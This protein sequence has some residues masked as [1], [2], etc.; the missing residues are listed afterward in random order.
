MWLEHIG[1]HVVMS[2]EDWHEDE[3]ALCD[4][5]ETEGELLGCMIEDCKKNV[6]WQCAEHEEK[7]AICKDCYSEGKR[8]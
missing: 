2:R 7:G 6:C 1:E 5:C 3:Y 4:I 8:L